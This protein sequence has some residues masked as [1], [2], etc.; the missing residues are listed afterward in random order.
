MGDL[1]YKTGSRVVLE[2]KHKHGLTDLAVLG[3]GME[4]GEQT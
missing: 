2:K 1:A 4:S 3:Q